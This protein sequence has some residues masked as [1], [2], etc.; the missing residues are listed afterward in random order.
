MAVVEVIAQIKQ[1]VLDEISAL[2]NDLALVEKLEVDYAEEL[3]L[4]FDK[5][6]DAGVLQSGSASAATDKIFSL[7]E[8]NAELAP[9]DAKIAE[10]EA[11]VASMQGQV[12]SIPQLVAEG[13]A[14]FKAELKAAYDAQ[15]VAESQGETGFGAMLA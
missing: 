9:R 11:T 13:V 4:E 2:Q 15:Q 6:F 12:S 1:G 8:M 3:R 5:G 14:A 10:L 7:E